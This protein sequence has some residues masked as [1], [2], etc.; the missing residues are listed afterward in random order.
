[1]TT[2]VLVAVVWLLLDLLTVAFMANV[3][4]RRGVR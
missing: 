3:K 2:I 4:K 1:M